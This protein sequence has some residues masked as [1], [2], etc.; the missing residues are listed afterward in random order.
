MWSRFVRPPSGDGRSEYSD[1]RRRYAE[2]ARHYHTAMHVVDCLARFDEMREPAGD[3]VALEL[4]IWFHDAIYDPRADDNEEQSAQLAV[5]VIRR[6]GGTSGL[7]ARVCALILATK[8]HLPNHEPDAPW[9]LDIDLA[10]LGQPSEI[11]DTYER[12]IRAEYAWVSEATFRAKR[13]E[14]LKNFLTRE[15]IYLTSCFRVRF[16]VMARANLKRSIAASLRRGLTE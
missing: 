9:L 16:E 11:F 10:I 12:A 15:Q 6:A 14:V 4:A 3:P 2:P 8:T 7:E 13:A 5:G 1:L